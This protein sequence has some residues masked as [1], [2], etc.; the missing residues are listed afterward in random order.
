MITLFVIALIITSASSLHFPLNYHSNLVQPAISSE[1][2]AVGVSSVRSSSSSTEFVLSGCSALTFTVPVVLNNNQTF[3]LI[4]DTGSTTFAVASSLC[5]A[6]CNSVSPLYSPSNTAETFGTA[7]T[8]YGDGSNWFG[9]IFNEYVALATNESTITNDSPAATMKIVA[10]TTN[11]DFFAESNC[12][13]Q[14]STNIYQGIIGFA[15]ASIAAPGSSAI[16]DSMNINEFTLQLCFGSGNMWIYHY[17]ARFIVNEFEY[18][19]IMQNTF[20]V[21]QVSE[22]EI[23]LPDHIIL[24][25]SIN[26]IVD[27]GTTNF[28]LTPSLFQSFVNH[29]YD[30][31]SFQS[32]FN[33]NRNFFTSGFCYTTSWT[34]EQLNA[35]L[36]K[37]KIKFNNGVTLVEIDAVESY[38]LTF[39][40]N[41]NQLVYCPGLAQSSHNF[42]VLGYGFM[43]QFTTRF[44]IINNRIGFAKTN[45]CGHSVTAGPFYEVTEWSSC[46]GVDCDENYGIQHSLNVT[47]V[48]PDGQHTNNDTFCANQQNYF[49]RYCSISSSP[50]NCDTTTNAPVVFTSFLIAIIVISS[51]LVLTVFVLIVLYCSKIDF[52]GRNAP[53]S[54]RNQNPRTAV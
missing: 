51:V 38:L 23:D 44:D 36:P 31:V 16:I 45:L 7:S 1:E 9:T 35:A 46:E 3:H 54:R 4:V 34:K 27:S 13:L 19:P 24:Q 48:F 47:C 40:Y 8:T 11:Q 33:D 20:Y 28:I 22:I 18:V 50:T 49:T 26:A 6:S 39:L 30:S 17:D 52:M 5:D 32:A 25:G 43:N 2:A 41:G 42:L 10:I 29:I 37:W 53:M 21:V 15:Y 12:Y 14:P